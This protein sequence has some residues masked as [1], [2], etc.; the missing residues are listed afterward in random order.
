MN[1]LLTH[2]KQNTEEERTKTQ[3]Q[4][5]MNERTNERT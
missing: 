5:N 2:Q 3:E 1:A 4:K